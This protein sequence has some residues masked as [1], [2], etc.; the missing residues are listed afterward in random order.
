M[1]QSIL[2]WL[3]GSAGNPAAVPPVPA[4]AGHRKTMILFVLLMIC[5]ISYGG[6]RA[7]AWWKNQSSNVKW[8][9]NK[10]KATG[11]WTDVIEEKARSL[12]PKIRQ[13]AIRQAMKTGRPETFP[14]IVTLLVDSDKT[15]K[16]EAHDAMVKAGK[17]ADDADGKNSAIGKDAIKAL[18]DALSNNAS[19]EIK[20][21][22]CACLIKIGKPAVEQVIE[23]LVSDNDI[24][25]KCAQHTLYKI[26]TPAKEALEKAFNDSKRP[27][28]VSSGAEEVLNWLETGKAP[29][30]C[31]L[32]DKA[33]AE[34][35]IKAIADAKEAEYEAE[36]A[37]YKTKLE[38]AI[39][40]AEA[41]AAKRLEAK[42]AKSTTLLLEAMKENSLAKKQLAETIKESNI[43][44]ARMQTLDAD[45]LALLARAEELQPPPQL[46]PRAVAPTIRRQPTPARR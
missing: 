16:D 46:A 21:R 9:G 41:A 20:V 39:A 8:S 15:V 30:F 25:H 29:E 18:V 28:R 10:I 1:F 26:G 34:A 17:C 38:L 31:P 12:D 2:V 4:V 19:L 44:R 45:L 43:L 27:A 32:A 14:A 36:K 22:A 24:V 37:E 40:K 7:F 11:G 42:E 33:K 5:G 13:T 3:L 23:A 35:E 6:H